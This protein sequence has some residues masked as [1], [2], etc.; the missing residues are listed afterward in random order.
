MV[1]P[2]LRRQLDR[3]PPRARTAVELTIATV[4]DAGRD[5]VPGLAAEI[6]F[7]ALLSLPPLLLLAAAAAGLVGDAV[8]ADVRVQLVA[9]LEELALQVFSP[10]TVRQTITPTLQGLLE[11]EA[12]SVLSLSFAATIYSASRV[13]RVV[14]HA[15]TIAYDQ[16]EAR[17]SWVA[18]V[19]GLGYTVV[20]LVGGL[21]VVPLIVAGPRLG[22]IIERRLGIDMALA[23]IWAVA[24]WPVS[25]VV[26]TLAVAALYHFAV[27][28]STPF[29]REL[30]GAVLATVL[31]LVSSV[32]LRI[33][34]QQAFG[35]DALY[36]PLAAPLALLVWLYLQGIALL[37]G[38]E[39]NAEIEK[40]YPARREEDPPSL[41]DVAKRVATGVRGL[42]QRAG[43]G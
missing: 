35:G 13:L 42:Q 19:L 29:H 36:A 7:W 43:R 20:G 34:T 26:V 32:G 12:T 14:V 15:V 41:A 24:Y 40:A 31:G 21:V 4:R 37:M 22:A 5:R 9:R 3:L 27:P 30:P 8:G 33:Y 25:L 11:A 18:R 6:S 17:P 2:R 1:P 38:A 10:G 28:W 16:Q 23:E 39:L